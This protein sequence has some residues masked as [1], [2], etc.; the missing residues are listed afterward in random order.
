MKAPIVQKVMTR[1]PLEIE[2]IDNIAN[3]KRMME[4]FGIRHVP[5]MKG[6]HLKGI[7]SQRDILKAMVERG[8]DIDDLPIDDF[9]Q[10]DVL[11]VSPMT[12]VNEVAER[13]LERD[14][15]SAVVVDGE[16]VVG[17]FTLTDALRTLQN[18]FGTR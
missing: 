4:L 13:M 2:Q 8:S 9:C 7:I 14:V 17:I 5:V 10:H 6:L 16:Y 11:T 12:P 3:A 1:L 18:A 15:G